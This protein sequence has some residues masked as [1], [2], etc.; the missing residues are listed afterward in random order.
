VKSVR[1]KASSF[2]QPYSALSLSLSRS[3]SRF[4]VRALRSKTYAPPDS[5]QL[6]VFESLVDV[7]NLI[8]GSVC[9]IVCDDGSSITFYSNFGTIDIMSIQRLRAHVSSL[10]NASK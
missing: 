7:A 5:L 2:V 9:Q 3:L 6:D 8:H 1:R 4:P 10:V